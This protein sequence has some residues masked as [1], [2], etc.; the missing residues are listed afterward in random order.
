MSVIGAIAFAV[1]TLLY[2][3]RAI[4]NACYLLA[5]TCWTLVLTRVTLLVLI[6]ATSMNSLHGVYNGPICLLLVVAVVLSIAAWLQLWTAP[7]FGRDC[8][9]LPAQRRARDVKPE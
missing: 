5:L 1:T 4:R 6:T 2:P 9:G 8:D 3:R 7:L